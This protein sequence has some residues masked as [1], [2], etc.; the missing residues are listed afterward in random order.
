MR[1]T[2]WQCSQSWKRLTSGRTNYG[3]LVRKIDAWLHEARDSVTVVTFDY[4]LLIDD[5]LQSLVGM[6]VSS[7][8]G[9]VSSEHWRYLKLHGSVDWG[10]RVPAPGGTTHSKRDQARRVLIDEAEGLEAADGATSG[11]IRQLRRLLL[12]PH[13]FWSPPSL[14][15]RKPSRVSSALRVT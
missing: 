6:E 10:R 2:I 12:N 4:D 3:G 7:I 5:A 1:P 11:G 13:P 8:G 14:S 9:H 15:P